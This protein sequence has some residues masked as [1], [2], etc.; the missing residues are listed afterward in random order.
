MPTITGD[1][2]FLVY[3]APKTGGTWLRRALLKHCGA[4]RL[5]GEHNPYTH[6]VH[7]EYPE[8]KL[9]GTIRDPW[10]WYCSFYA[11]AARSQHYGRLW[12]W[13]GRPEKAAQIER[14][15]L[16]SLNQKERELPSFR[17]VLWGLTHPLAV[18][19]PKVAGVFF[20]VYD[21]DRLGVGRDAG[22]CQRV[23]RSVYRAGP[24]TMLCQG[25]LVEEASELFEVDLR[26][27]PPCN[28]AENAQPGKLWDYRLWYDNDMVEWVYQA[29][30]DMLYEY[31][32]T[33]G[34][35]LLP[36]GGNP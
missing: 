29:D 16:G 2:R 28:T 20:E 8:A 9:V 10:S 36:F 21:A 5:A 18:E 22:F 19:P 27:V 23:H 7:K 31:E 13:A 35:K 17:D 11:H 12:A 33:Q 4:E 25:N 1:R 30:E 26:D 14:D 3:H 32:A 34:G 15:K 24:W 6:E